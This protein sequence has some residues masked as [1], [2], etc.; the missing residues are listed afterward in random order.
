MLLSPYVPVIVPPAAL[1][2]LTVSVVS[3]GVV[4]AFGDVTPPIALSDLTMPNSTMVRPVFAEPA[5]IV[6]SFVAVE[7]ALPAP[8]FVSKTVAL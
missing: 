4:P 3:A 8:P 6:K 1:S 7:S 5:T 2:A